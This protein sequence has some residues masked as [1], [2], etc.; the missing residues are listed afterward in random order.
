MSRAQRTGGGAG[1]GFL[2]VFGTNTHFFNRFLVF[3]K[4]VAQTFNFFLVKNLEK[5]PLKR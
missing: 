3:L 1:V 2:L 5:T 4:K